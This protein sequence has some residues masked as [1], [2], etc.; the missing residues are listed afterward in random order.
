MNTAALH[1]SLTLLAWLNV[2]LHLLGLVFAAVGM[3]PGSPLM[4]LADRQAYLARIPAGWSVGWG[5]WMLSSL[6]LVAFFAVL[7][8]HLPEH[9]ALARLAVV[10][11]AAGAMVDLFCDGIYITV[12]PA[13]AAR[14]SEA[15]AAF[16]AAEGMALAGGLIVANGAYSVGT[17][18]LT[19]CLR[20]RPGIRPLLV[21]LGYAVFGLG[22][23][24]VVAGLARN[25]HLAAFA[26]VPTVGLYCLWAV[27]AARA[28]E[29]PAA[30][31]APG[32][33]PEK[34]S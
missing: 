1:R 32:P 4:S 27:L 13:L 20:R 25:A 10:V 30:E 3:R 17:L 12:L 18:L 21:G 28:V 9:A 14:G 34:P 22:M 19:F 16:L 26:T 24:L 15:E 23:V 31:S 29:V 7:A 2:G 33:G 5:T 6:A 11:V 8:H